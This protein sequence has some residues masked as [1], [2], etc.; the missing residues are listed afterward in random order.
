MYTV[1]CTRAYNVHHTVYYNET[2]VRSRS[3]ILSRRVASSIPASSPPIISTGIRH[4][5]PVATTRT[6]YASLDRPS[7]IDSV[8]LGFYRTVS[9]TIVKSRRLSSNIA[10]GIWHLCFVLFASSSLPPPPP[11]PLLQ[12]YHHPYFSSSTTTTTVTTSASHLNPNSPL[13]NPQISPIFHNFIFN[14]ALVRL[15]TVQCTQYNVQCT[16]YSVQ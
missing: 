7:L 16:Q 9:P 14:F 4:P 11:P 10:H 8:R 6:L 13:Y 2:R 15:Y 12:N 3:A 5:T 1:Q